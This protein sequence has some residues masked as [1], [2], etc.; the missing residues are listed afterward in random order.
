MEEILQSLGLTV[1]EAIELYYRQIRKNQRIPF[2][3]KNPNATTRETMQETN[4][5]KNLVESENAV[6]MFTL[7]KFR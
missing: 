3:V 7:L 4:E 5:G 6:E 1:S 2:M